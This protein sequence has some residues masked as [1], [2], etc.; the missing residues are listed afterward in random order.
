LIA[1][2]ERPYTPISTARRAGDAARR[3]RAE[4]LLAVA[5]GSLTPL[6]V[7]ERAAAYGHRA[8]RRITLRRLLTAQPG[9]GEA[10]ADRMLTRMLTCLRGGAPT[11]TDRDSMVKLTIAWLLDTRTGG[12]RWAAFTDALRR[13]RQVNAPWPGFP[14]AP[15]PGEGMRS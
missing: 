2:D 5:D 4:H 13:T 10:T 15:P 14:Y 6:E 12:R 7:I 1:A 3:H 11:R 8:L 9:V